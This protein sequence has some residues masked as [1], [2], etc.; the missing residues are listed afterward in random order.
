[1]PPIDP[2]SGGLQSAAATRVLAV[3]WLART[4]GIHAELHDLPGEFDLNLEARAAGGRYV[5]KIMREGCDPGLVRMQIDALQHL[6]AQGLGA[7][8]PPVIAALDGSTLVRFDADGSD[9]IAWVLG[10][11]PGP[12]VIVRSLDAGDGG[13]DRPPDRGH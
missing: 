1:M 9:R 12:D 13:V 5:L 7:Q 6:V 2:A 11:Q 8:V 10:W 4:F 3:A